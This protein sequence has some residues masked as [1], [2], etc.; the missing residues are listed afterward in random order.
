[1]IDVAV[2]KRVGFLSALSD[3]D[4]QALLACTKR[5]PFQ[6]GQEI[7]KQGQRNASLFVVQEGLLH[8]RRVAGGREI[9]LGRLEPGNFFGELS[10]F[11]PGPTAAAVDAVSDGV[12]LEISRA[13]LEEFLSHHPVAA[14]EI[15]QSILKDVSHRLRRA[16]ERLS[17]TVVWGGL[18]HP[19]RPDDRQQRTDNRLKNLKH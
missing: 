11:D 12:V 16:D 5:I 13:C 2:V 6:K 9:F 15:L 10:L 4:L 18:L 3:E 7:L 14:A 1:M 19:E 17:D 8:A